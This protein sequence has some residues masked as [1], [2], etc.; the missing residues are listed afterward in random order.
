MLCALKAQIDWGECTNPPPTAKEY[1]TVMGG[2]VA[3]RL[4]SS[5]S[6][7]AVH[8]QHC[9]LAGMTAP[10][11]KQAFL[12]LVQ[13]WPLHRASVFEAVQSYT[14]QWPGALWLAVD[15]S[16]LHLLEPRT[17]NVLASCH[18]SDIV[19]YTPSLSSLM[20]VTGAAGRKASKYI[21]TTSQVSGVLVESHETIRSRYSSPQNSPQ[22]PALKCVAQ[23]PQ[24][25]QLIRD[26]TRVLAARKTEAA[27]AHR[28]KPASASRPTSILYKAPPPTLHC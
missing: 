24:I 17:R 12:A 11:S 21:F 3:A 10:Q 18:Y 19:N 25:A 1:R 9:I 16:G 6:V 14:S 5:L 7:E 27:A 28:K 23:A 2:C 8:T 13:S 15:Q 20:V 22:V 26:Y 4:A